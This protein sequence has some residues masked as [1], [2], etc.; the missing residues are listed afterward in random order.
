MIFE[1][2][3]VSSKEIFKGRVLKLRVDM[4]E[5]PDGG[6]AERELVDH[7][8]GVGVVAL[9]ENME[10]L[11]VKQYRKPL[12]TVT[13]EIPAGKLDP[14]EHHAVCGE[15]ELEE[16][17][18]CCAKKFEYL[19]CFHP[20]PGFINEITHLYLATELY[21]GEAHPDP[22]EYLDLIKMPFAEALD[23]VMRNEISDAKTVIGIL[24]TAKK[25]EEKRIMESQS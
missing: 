3:T 16:E 15:R 18:G 24:K 6:L 19:G 22:D 2:K 5:M 25:L 21:Q 12:E 23:A 17:T 8:G 7:P 9:T 14:G 13:M 20:S 11:L 1:E 4:V 10:I